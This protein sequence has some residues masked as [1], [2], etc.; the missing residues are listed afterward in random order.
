MPSNLVPSLALA[1]A[2]NPVVYSNGCHLGFLQTQPGACAFGDPSSA[3]T[4]VL[5]GDLHAAQ[6]F[7][8]LAQLADADHFRLV[9]M[10]KSACSAADVRVWN[11]S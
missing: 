9:S 7:P 5:F 8:A 6:W 10:T 11:S 3:T 1:S 4:V 2:D